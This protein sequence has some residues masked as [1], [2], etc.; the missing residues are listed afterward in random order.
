MKKILIDNIQD[1]MILAR[2][3][4]GSTDNVLLSKGIRLTQSLG[5]RLKNW[6]VP[7]IWIEGEEEQKVEKSTHETISQVDFIKHLEDKFSQVK[8]N[9]IMHDLFVAVKEFKTKALT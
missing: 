8:D 7:F 2:D 6:G 5:K 4:C 9:P 1:G 3:V